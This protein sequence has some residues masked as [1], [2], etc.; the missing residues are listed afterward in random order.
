MPF[1]QDD[2][3]LVQ[4]SP[5]F[6]GLHDARLHEL[7]P[8]AMQRQDDLLGLGFRGYKT[9]TWLLACGPNGLSVGR[10]RFV[11]L[12]KGADLA[13]GNEPHLMPE[14][15]QRATPLVSSSTSLHHD[16]CTGTIGEPLQ[17]A[18]AFE[19]LTLNAARFQINPVQLE[20]L[21]RDING[22]DSAVH[23]DLLGW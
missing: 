2:A 4:D 15:L 20:H 14:S 9:H 22:N 23:E 21:L 17:Q 19:L 1:R 10:V 3:E 6:V 8:N 11:T 12:D 13:G 5:Q 7:H 16:Q 18:A